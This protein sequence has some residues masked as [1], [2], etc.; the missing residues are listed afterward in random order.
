MAKTNFTFTL[1]III[2]IYIISAFTGTFTEL[3]QD[4]SRTPGCLQSS[5]ISIINEDTFYLFGGKTTYTGAETGPFAY[6]L[7]KQNWQI[8]FP[9]KF[10]NARYEHSAIINGNNLVIFGG[11]FD[12][13][14]QHTV[15]NDVWIYI[16]DIP[17]WTKINDNG[18]KIHGHNAFYE[19]KSNSM[20][21]FGGCNGNEEFYNDLWSF[22]FDTNSWKKIETSGPKPPGRCVH[23]AVTSNN[24]MI[25]FG[26]YGKDNTY[27]N[28]MWV[29]HYGDGSYIWESINYASDI[30]PTA[31]YSHSSV[32]RDNKILIFGGWGKDKTSNDLWTFDI[33]KKMW[34]QVLVAGKIPSPR[35]GHAVGITPNGDMFVFGG[36]ENTDIQ[37]L[38]DLWVFKQN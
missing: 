33:E 8:P 14:E 35:A 4:G 17:T 16:Q 10:A 6:S 13:K 3:K 21:V 30:I 19:P 23:S 28:D 7:T 34:L 31:R 26:G 18:P 36:Y 25:I 5:T 1:F 32:L 12:L 20:I 15:F 9:K 22:S 24:T 27:F 29:L 37:F 2:Q 38:C 11:R